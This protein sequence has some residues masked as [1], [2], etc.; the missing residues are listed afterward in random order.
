VHSPLLTT[1]SVRRH[2]LPRL[3]HALLLAALAHWPAAAHAH[4]VLEEP[5]A[6]SE[7][8]IFGGP[9]KSA[10]CGQADPGSPVQPT[11]A[12]TTYTQGQTITL[13][14]N[15]VIFHP[16]H[17]R[18][19]IAADQ[20]SLPPD[21]VVTPG[22]TPCGSAEIVT[23]PTLPLLADG[24]LVH[25][26]ALTNPQSMEVTLPADFTC[27]ECTLQVVEFMSNH[28]LNDPGGCYY[29]HCA[30]VTVLPRPTD[31]GAAAADDTP[32][33]GCGCHTAGSPPT[34][35]FLLMAGMVLLIR[36]RSA[37]P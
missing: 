10:P 28:V 26:A 19:L 13:S 25:T 17:Y 20:A 34:G 2:P 31:A 4:F 6:Y 5:P 37:L 9:Q 12:V 8:D 16:G 7:Q 36:R 14:I 15:E 22:S 21:P 18:V 33:A 32:D 3:N 30:T 35:T 1:S 23:N 24:L 27:T 11:G 29:H